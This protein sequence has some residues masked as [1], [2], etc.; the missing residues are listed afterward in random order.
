[1]VKDGNVGKAGRLRPHVYED[2]WCCTGATAMQKKQ[3]HAQRA[4]SRALSVP[5][6]CF[7]GYFMSLLGLHSILQC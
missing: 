1:M 2:E 3:Q 5:R 6:F 4:G 7:T